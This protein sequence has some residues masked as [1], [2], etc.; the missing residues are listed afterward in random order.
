MPKARFR[1]LQFLHAGLIQTLTCGAIGLSAVAAD[2][3]T[4][5]RNELSHQHQRAAAL[6]DAGQAAEAERIYRSIAQYDP[7]D[8]VAYNALLSLAASR[9]LQSDSLAAIAAKS[10]L[11]ERFVVHQTDRFVLISDVSERHTIQN[12]RW[13]ERAHAEFNRF[14]RECGLR[15][16]PLQHKLVCV[17]FD[18]RDEYLKFAQTEDGLKNI[19]FTGYYSPR[20]DRMVFSMEDRER[21][22]VGAEP[23]RAANAPDA[24]AVLGFDARGMENEQ[25]NRHD[26][27]CDHHAHEMP[28]ASAAKCV[29][30]TIHQ[31]MFHT[32]LMSPEV[33]YPLWICEGLSTA[34]ETD[35][36]GKPFGPDH[37]YAPRLQAFQTLLHNGDLIPLREFVTVTQLTAN[38]HWI[39]R[40][41]Y[42]QS[43]ALVTWLCRERSQQV[44][45]YLHLMRSQPGGKISAARHLNLF[46]SVFGDIDNVERDWLAYE[47]A[48]ARG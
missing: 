37:D 30:E 8:D 7:Q 5:N 48:G 41:M 46:E 34:F 24:K 39:T 29:H 9:S 38:K 2:P 23:E 14:A 13:V 4:S 12:A 27:S 28:S 18:S 26:E 31:L 45:D 42:Q 36:P 25:A 10:R 20:H 32:R 19:N 3:S 21:P 17:L 47:R 15:P 1:R 16:L 33:Q 43:Y 35:L 22:N 11:P 44:R 40:V 6:A